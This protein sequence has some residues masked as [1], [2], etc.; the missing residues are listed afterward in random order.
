LTIQAVVEA[1]N[2]LLI[3]ANAYFYYLDLENLGPI[4]EGDLVIQGSILDDTLGP[5]L[6]VVKALVSDTNEYEYQELQ[7]IFP[8]KM[9]LTPPEDDAEL[10]KFLIPIHL[11]NEHLV[12]GLQIHVYVHDRA[13][14]NYD[15]DSQD[16]IQFAPENRGNLLLACT[17]SPSVTSPTIGAISGEDQLAQDSIVKPSVINEETNPYFE[18]T[19]AEKLILRNVKIATDY[20]EVISLQHEGYHLICSHLDASGKVLVDQDQMWKFHVLGEYGSSSDYGVEDI[21]WVKC[22]K[23]LGTLPS[24]PFYTVFHDYDLSRPDDDVS[25]KMLLNMHG[26]FVFFANFIFP[27]LW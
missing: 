19:D 15:D 2:R 17:F 21:Q 27:L 1:E 11:E 18:E 9:I 8:S 16:E 3:V 20:D 14:L 5:A 25:Y 4:I 24:L 23:S 13:T 10:T 7:A 22:L 26:L 12:H 6:C